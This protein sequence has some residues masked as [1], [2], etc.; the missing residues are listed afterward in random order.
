M[1]IDVFGS[2]EAAAM[3][4]S[5]SQKGDVA[6]TASFM[7]GPLA[8]VV[9]ESGGFVEPG[10]GEVGLAAFGGPMHYKD[11]KKTAETFRIVEGKRWSVPGDFATV[12]VDGSMKLLGR[13]S[14][15]I[16][17]GGEKVFVEEVEEVLKLHASVRD[18]VCVGIPNERFGETVCAIVELEDA[19]QPLDSDDV[20]AHVKKKLAG[21]KGGPR[22]ARSTTRR[23][24]PTLAANLAFEGAG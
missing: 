5:V 3:G 10:S 19:D 21:Y 17:T 22:R 24:E 12:E 8:Q 11:E 2:S 9:S 18:A 4:S 13:G 15:C 16:N 1:L 7:V 20:V 23:Y 6:E 14:V